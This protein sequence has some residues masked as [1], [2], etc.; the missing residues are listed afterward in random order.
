MTATRANWKVMNGR[1]VPLSPRMKVIVEAL[2]RGE[3]YGAIARAHKISK[4][5]VHKIRVI[6]GLPA[7]RQS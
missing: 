7:R 4:Q 6:A 3:K 1:R 2:Q 5:R